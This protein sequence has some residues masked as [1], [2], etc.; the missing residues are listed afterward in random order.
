MPELRQLRY[1]VTLMQEMHFGRAAEVLGISQPSLSQSI[2][3]LEEELGVRLLQ[4]T[5]R[6]VKPTNAGRVFQDEAVQT[7]KQLEQ[8]CRAA[9]RAAR[10]ENGGLTIG[11]ATT[12]IMGGLHERI[13]LYKE[14]YP[15]VTLVLREL[16]VDSLIQQLHQGELDLICTDSEVLDHGLQSRTLDSPPWVLA[17][18]TAHPLAGKRNLHLSDLAREQFIFPTNHAHHTLHD[19]MFQA[20]KNAGF[21]P[22]RRYFADTVPAAVLMAAAQLGVAIVYELPGFRPPG[23]VYKRLAGLD[24]TLSMQMAW[25]KGELT[26]LAANF[27]RLAVRR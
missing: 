14:R 27:L 16:L 24:L 3:Q 21:L 2:R 5:S 1:F 15:Q 12:A 17:I 11:F 13:R 22:D 9:Q 10:G 25:R 8:S 23:V 19:R 4:R 20:C 6:R 7:L 26:P 18:S